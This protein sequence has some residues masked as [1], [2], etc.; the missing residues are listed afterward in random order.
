MAIITINSGGANLGQSGIA[1]VNLDSQDLNI[2]VPFTTIPFDFNPQNPPAGTQFVGGASIGP[3]T[4]GPNEIYGTWTLQFDNGCEHGFTVQGTDANCDNVNF[5]ITSPGLIGYEGQPVT[6]YVTVALP[7]TISN[8][9]NDVFVLGT[10]SYDITTVVPSGEGYSN[11]GET[12]DCPVVFNDVLELVDCELFKDLVIPNG[13]TGQL[14]TQV[15]GW[16]AG[17]ENATW[18]LDQTNYG[19]GSIGHT[20]TITLPTGYYAIDGEGNITTVSIDC[21]VISDGSPEFDCAN[22]NIV[23]LDGIVGNN[24][25]FTSEPGITVS[26]DQTTATYVGGTSNYIFD[27][28]IPGGYYDAGT[29]VQCTVEGIGQIRLECEDYALSLADGTPGGAI[30]LNPSGPHII[31]A[32]NGT[33]TQVE[34]TASGTINQ[35]VVGTNQQYIVSITVPEQ[36]PDGIPYSN[37]GVTMTCPVQATACEDD[38]SFTI[39][40]NQAQP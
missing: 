1:I 29:V 28:T 40:D 37:V 6:D 3:N 14:I 7:F 38:I 30:S 36:S 8:T 23:V 12:I 39:N 35:Y 13:I 11:A 15:T 33:I 18:T 10:T 5:T 31:Y 22:A 24:V 34:H 25:D 4:L 27:V 2:Q 20:I 19:D 26:I 32:G 16:P 9:E 17:W 21:D